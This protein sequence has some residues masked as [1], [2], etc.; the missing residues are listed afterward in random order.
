MEKFE[1]KIERYRYT[2][3]T[4]G[5]KINFLKSRKDLIREKIASRAAKELTDGMYVNLGIGI[6]G[7]VPNYV[8][9][10]ITV[11]L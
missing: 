10:G 3:K 11:M 4:T 2:E 7:L 5:P 9:D 8:P 6:P 1:K